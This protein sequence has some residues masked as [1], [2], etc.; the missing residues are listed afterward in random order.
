MLLIGTPLVVTCWRDFI[1]SWRSSRYHS[2]NRCGPHSSLFSKWRSQFNKYR[3]GVMTCAARLSFPIND[4]SVSVLILLKLMPLLCQW[5]RFFV[6]LL[7]G[8]LSYSECLCPILVILC[9]LLVVPP[10]PVSLRR[11]DRLVSG[12]LVAVSV[13]RVYE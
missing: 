10:P 6:S 12:V 1:R 3:S 8:I 2:W 7:V 4:S 11:V 9:S 5:S 13:R